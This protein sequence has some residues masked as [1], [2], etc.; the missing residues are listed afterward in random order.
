MIFFNGKSSIKQIPAVYTN[1]K[2]ISVVVNSG[3]ANL[4]NNYLLSSGFYTYK[5]DFQTGKSVQSA[6]LKSIELNKTA[7]MNLQLING[8]YQ[9]ESIFYIPQTSQNNSAPKPSAKYC[10]STHSVVLMDAFL[11]LVFGGISVVPQRKTFLTATASAS[12]KI[13]PTL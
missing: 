11:I 5:P 2:S 6:D 12:L 1:S 4:T 7:T 13:E 3:Q 10:Q 8:V 9:V